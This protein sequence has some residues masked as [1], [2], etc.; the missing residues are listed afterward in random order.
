MS[1]HNHERGASPEFSTRAAGLPGATGSELIDLS[2]PG[3]TRLSRGLRRLC[4]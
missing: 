1:A 4:R 2:L 3:L